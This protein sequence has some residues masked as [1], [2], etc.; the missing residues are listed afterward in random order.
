MYYIYTELW[1]NYN[2]KLY[3]AFVKNLKKYI[4]AFYGV[5]NRNQ[6]AIPLIIEEVR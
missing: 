4:Y 1:A 6:M 2:H 5:R 3:G